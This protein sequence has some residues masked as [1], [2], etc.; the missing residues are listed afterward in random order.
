M[1]LGIVVEGEGDVQAVPVVVRRLLTRQ[2]L[3]Q[4][5]IP[6][7]FRLTKGK[8][9]KQA[10]LERAVELMARRTAPDGALLV[11]LDA[12]TDCPAEI[13]P[14]LLAWVKRARG[15]RRAS[16][17]VARHE[18]EAW[19]LAAAKSLRGHRGLPADLQPPH[20][21]EAVRDPKGWLASKMP[22]GYS[23]TLDQAALAAI[24][25]LASAEVLPSFAKLVRDLAGLTT[26]IG[27]A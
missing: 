9:L 14:R 24:F 10:E 8:M 6:R 21:A 26:G 23:E 17:V 11:L 15:D 2:G 25:D 5:D 18:F 27:P 20:D 12:D 19:F 22:N 7:P 3:T 4:L 1:R 13:G 16:V